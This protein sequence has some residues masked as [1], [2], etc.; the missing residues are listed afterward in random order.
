[1][2]ASVSDVL[3]RH[4]FVI[5]PGDVNDMFEV[6][7]GDHPYFTTDVAFHSF[8]HLVRGS[9]DELEDYARLTHHN[10]MRAIEILPNCSTRASPRAMRSVRPRASGVQLLPQPALPEARVPS[11]G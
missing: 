7:G 9:L 1:L 2:S 8:M 4:G 5:T 10:E 6:Y 3:S 11:H